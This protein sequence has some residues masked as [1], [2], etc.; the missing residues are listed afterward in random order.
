MT[1]RELISFLKV[2]DVSYP[3]ALGNLEI[4]NEKDFCRYPMIAYFSGESFLNDMR[5]AYELVPKEDGCNSTEKD[6]YFVFER[7][8]DGNFS[9]KLKK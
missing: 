4:I 7:D 6:F 2:Y 1:V 3:E 9:L 8:K 5:T